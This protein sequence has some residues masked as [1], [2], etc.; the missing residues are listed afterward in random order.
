MNSRVMRSGT[1]AIQTFPIARLRPRGRAGPGGEPDRRRRWFA[2]RRDSN[3]SIEGD[4]PAS[5]IEKWLTGRWEKMEG[6]R[7]AGTGSVIASLCY[8]I[9]QGKHRGGR[10]RTRVHGTRVRAGPAYSRPRPSGQLRAPDRS[11]R[12]FD[13]GLG[14]AATEQAH[15]HQGH[16]Q[17]RQQHDHARRFGNGGRHDD[18]AR[19]T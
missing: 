14:L 8:P 15:E 10:R 11:H 2:W 3:P 13:S 16:G 6:G 7:R 1:P 12:R 5:G 9:L 17:P 18:S 19:P 4:Q